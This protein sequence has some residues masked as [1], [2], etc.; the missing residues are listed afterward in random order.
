MRLTKPEIMGS[1]TVTP[2]YRNMQVLKLG[3][4]ATESVAIAADTQGRSKLRAL[5]LRLHGT[6]DFRPILIKLG[7]ILSK[8]HITTGILFSNTTCSRYFAVFLAA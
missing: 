4:N 3:R 5:K 7:Q 2:H 6:K 8:F 1:M